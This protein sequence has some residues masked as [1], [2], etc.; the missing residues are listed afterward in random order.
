MDEK[1]EEK[2]HICE[3]HEK[4][5]CQEHKV[6]GRSYN[7]ERIANREACSRQLELFKCNVCLELLRKPKTCSNCKK[8]FC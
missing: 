6:S 4:L 1:Y 2:E 5:W 3:E 8:N 7:V